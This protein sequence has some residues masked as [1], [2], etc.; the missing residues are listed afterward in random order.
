M[1]NMGWNIMGSMLRPRDSRAHMNQQINLNTALMF[2]NFPSH[3]PLL[4]QMNLYL[5]RCLVWRK[6][7]QNGNDGS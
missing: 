4:G 2:T 1:W 5:Y 7:S 6:S 3:Y